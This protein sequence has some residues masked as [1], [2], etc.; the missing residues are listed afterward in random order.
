MRY[1]VIL[2]VGSLFVAI[3]GCDGRTDT[4][5][6][7]VTPTT[8]STAPTTTGREAYRE[9]WS[10]LG[11]TVRLQELL[12]IASSIDTFD[13]PDVDALRTRL[14]PNSRPCG[15][16]YQR[17]EPRIR[18]GQRRDGGLVRGPFGGVH[19]QGAVR[20][21]PRRRDV[22]HEPEATGKRRA[23]PRV[24]D[25]RSSTFCLPESAIASLT[26][27][28]RQRAGEQERAICLGRLANG[29]RW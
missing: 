5:T 29:S 27:R 23:D 28:V 20:R 14:R 15:P 9:A 11:L 7:T 16:F 18:G 24:H 8:T 21:R 22:I 19:L 3:L 12:A 17:A 10:V 4:T 1:L 2:L 6:T 26:S 25:E 13:Y